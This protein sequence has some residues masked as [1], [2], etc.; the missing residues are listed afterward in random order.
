MPNRLSRIALFFALLIAPFASATGQ[1]VKLD[2]LAKPGRVL[3]LRHAIAPG[4]GDPNGFRV[5]DC[6][7][8]R[9]LSSRGRA[10]ARRLGERL[11]AAGVVEAKVYSSQWCRCL[12]TGEMLGLGPVI[13]LR[14]L[15]SIFNRPDQRGPRMAALRAFL[16]GLPKDGPA[17]ILV[18]HQVTIRAL[19]GK[20]TPSGGGHLLQLNGTGAPELIGEIEAN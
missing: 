12:Q 7:T 9:N 11:A 3:L 8:Q 17:V 1:V 20:T 5:G 13:A 15:N 4:I 19:I 16:K 2:E 14:A 6:R 18:T 10:Q